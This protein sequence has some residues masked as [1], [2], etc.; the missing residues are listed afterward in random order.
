M[1]D[2]FFHFLP[3]LFYL[4]FSWPASHVVLSSLC[5]DPS[6]TH[7]AL[8]LSSAPCSSSTKCL[9]HTAVRLSTL[10]LHPRP[11]SSSG[12]RA[13]WI[14]PVAAWP[15]RTACGG[16][17]RGRRAVQVSRTGRSGAWP[18]GEQSRRRS[19]GRPASTVGGR[20]I[21]SRAHGSPHGSG[22][23]AAAAARADPLHGAVVFPNLAAEELARYPRLAELTHGRRPP[24]AAWLARCRRCSQASGTG[25]SVGHAG[26]ELLV[27]CG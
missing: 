15:A 7:I 24:C 27:C 5:S 12:T 17:A 3:C 2:F 10:P 14:S 21:C 6:L 4:I 20:A 13:R 22:A 19:G 25:G 9:R 16:L 18:A 1:A 26:S 8:L 11:G 23:G